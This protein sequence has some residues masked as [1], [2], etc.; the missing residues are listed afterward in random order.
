MADDFNLEVDMNIFNHRSLLDAY[1]RTSSST[2]KKNA[3]FD[4][5]SLLDHLVR[6]LDA[7]VY[8][9]GRYNCFVV[10][11]PKV[12]EI[13]APCFR[14]RIVHRLIA[15]R[16]LPFFDKRFIDDSFSNRATGGTHA[17]VER[18]TLFMRRL[19]A[20]A[21]YMQCD[22]QSYFTSIDKNI[23]FA[24]IERDLA[25][26]SAITA[27]ECRF[28]LDLIAIILGQDP[29]R[30]PHYTGNGH[31]LKSIPPHKS[32]FHAPKGVGLPIGC[33]T[34]QFFSNIYLN[35]LDQ[36]CKHTLKIR[37]YLRY[38]DD[39]VM[40]HESAAELGRWRDTIGVFLREKLRLKLHPRKTVMQPIHRGCDFLGYV[41]RPHVKLLRRRSV[42][43]FKQRLYFFN[44]LLDPQAFPHHNA[45][46]RHIFAKYVARGELTLPLAPTMDLLLSMQQTI[47]S[48]YG[49]FGHAHSFNLRRQIYLNHFNQLQNYFIPA[50]HFTKVKLRP[51]ATLRREGIIAL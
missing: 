42:R 28:L 51:V 44:H 17:A 14:D 11:E 6:D 18:L 29:A 33:L 9:P 21:Y 27:P 13:F 12:R 49:I 22:I 23:L 20:T 46:P 15:D 4:V 31:L 19:P 3:S 16:I 36:F 47:N 38:V 35:E 2:Q 37:H 43:A 48:Y 7:G 50:R 41:V 25:K 26:N 45:P 1:R 24:I 30:D 34:S 10:M 5:F 39:F 8:R 32:L 40:L